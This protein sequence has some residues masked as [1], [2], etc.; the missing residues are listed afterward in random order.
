MSEA[1]WD[2]RYGTDEYIY[3]TSPNTFLATALPAYVPPPADVIELGSGEG[4]NAVY[5]AQQGYRVTA[6]DYSL[7]GIAKT[8]RLARQAGVSVEVRHADVLQWEPDRRWDAVLISFLHLSPSG[9]PVLYQKIKEALAPGGVLVAEWF[10]P[11]QVTEGYRS[12]GPPNVEMMVTE[13]ELR[14][15]FSEEGIRLLES[16]TRTLD[17]GNYHSGPAAVVRLVWQAPE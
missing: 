10:R 12:G 3:S 1:F 7:A 4:R 2:E 8:E 13:Q 14:A 16:V 17:E 15:H 11:E 6:L 5:L 9:R